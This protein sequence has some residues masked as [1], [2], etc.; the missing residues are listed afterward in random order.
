MQKQGYK[1]H[2]VK[3]ATSSLKSVARRTNLLDVE[4]VKGYLANAQI[5]EARKEI[6]GI[7][8]ARFY[9]HMGIPFD[10]PRYRRIVDLP[11]IPLETEVDQQIGGVGRKTAVFLQ[12]LKET[13]MRPGEA[14]NHARL[15]IVDQPMNIRG[16]Y[17]AKMP[18]K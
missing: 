5:S 15:W 17:A 7:H 9:R 4:A 8:L 3:S 13:G 1:P 11:F 18:G 14:W 10:R 12:L 6:L 16:T 2:T